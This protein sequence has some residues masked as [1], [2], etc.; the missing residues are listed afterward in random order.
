MESVGAVIHTVAIMDPE[1]RVDMAVSVE[2]SPCDLSGSK[3]GVIDCY[4]LKGFVH[5]K[6]RSP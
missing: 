4:C 5:T 2:V 6:N 1:H 3:T